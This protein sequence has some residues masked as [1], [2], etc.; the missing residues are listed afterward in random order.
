MSEPIPT[1]AVRA[2]VRV[3]AHALGVW[4]PALE[5]VLLMIAAHE[6]HMGKFTRQIG[7]G[8]ALGWWQM[9]PATHD[10]C[11]RIVVPRRTHW[12][13]AL[14]LYASPRGLGAETMAVSP[15]YACAMACM[16][17]QRFDTLPTDASNVRSMAAFAKMRW[18]GG[19][20]ASVGDYELAYRE[21]VA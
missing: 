14:R 20:K 17:V 8:P 11:M 3:T 16:Q 12:M 19:G 2:L 21:R 4:T 10:D 5:E 9:E 6:S 1:S 7:G 15:A 18:N 13:P